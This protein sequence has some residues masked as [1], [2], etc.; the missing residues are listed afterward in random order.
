MDGGDFRLEQEE[1]KAILEG[2]LERLL[3]W[4]KDVDGRV[5]T[6][7]AI[8]IAMLG[9]LAARAP[10][11]DRW[12][13]LASLT[14]LLTLGTLFASVGFTFLAVFPRLVGPSESLVYFGSIAAFPEE[15]FTRKSRDITPE[16]YNS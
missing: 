6:T 2:T 9:I 15:V 11:F 12:W 10:P 4:I 16:S 7:L 14:F 1:R 3:G 5:Q 8:D 13:S